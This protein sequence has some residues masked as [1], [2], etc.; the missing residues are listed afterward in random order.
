M[1]IIGGY[2]T[3]A[4]PLE[5]GVREWSRFDWADR[6][7]EA[8]GA[9]LSGLGIHHADLEHLRVTRSWKEIRQVFDDHGLTVLELEFLTDWFIAGP[10]AARH[11]DLLFEAATEL[12]ARHIKVGNRYGRPVGMAR[13]TA[14]FA[15]LCAEAT[16]RHGAALLLEPMPFGTGAMSLDDALT[17]VAAVT[18]GN[19]GLVLDTWHL[20]HLGV[21]PGDLRR[22]P[23][24]DLSHFE[25]SDGVEPDPANP[26]GLLLEALTGRR[27]PGE[28]TYDVAAYARVAR[29]IGYA[30]PW[31][32][33]VRTSGRRDLPLRE[34]CRHTY[35]SASRLLASAMEGGMA[36]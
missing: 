28:G 21:A 30:G 4:G 23:L 31:G 17:I 16:H 32:V 5:P 8:A 1:E 7:A 6:C 15:A 33:E 25:L 2:D 10:D 36:Y 19:A 24:R 22:V 26:I 27:F 35:D 29:E 18:T 3:L 12:G 11:R 20:T 9:G 34:L 14:S 13:M